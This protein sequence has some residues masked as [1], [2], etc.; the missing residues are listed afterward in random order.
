V[1]RPIVAAKPGRRMG[2]G[3][4]LR[5]GPAASR[6]PGSR[7]ALPAPPPIDPGAGSQEC[8]PSPAHHRQPSPSVVARLKAWPSAASPSRIF[9]SPPSPPRLSGCLTTPQTSSLPSCG[10]RH[11]HHH[12][13]HHRSGPSPIAHRSPSAA[14]AFRSLAPA[15]D[16]SM[17]PYTV[18]IQALLDQA[19]LLEQERQ[20]VLSNSEFSGLQLDQLATQDTSGP[21]NGTQ[22]HVPRT[23]SYTVPLTTNPPV[24][25]SLALVSSF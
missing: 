2:G 3:Q 24:W 9:L 23:M 1:R 19:R 6:C 14:S 11:R 13:H 17:D 5:C 18:Q 25:I 12:H 20:R 7:S 4:G 10:P 21:F 15:M 8:C 16:P 22:S